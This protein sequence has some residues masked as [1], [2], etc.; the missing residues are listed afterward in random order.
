MA[1]SRPRQ[2]RGAGLQRRGRLPLCPSKNAPLYE[3]KGVR[4]DGPATAARYWGLSRPI[5]TSAPMSGRWRPG[6]I[7]GGLMIES[8][9]AI[10][11]LDDMLANV[12]GIGFCLIGEGDLSQELG[13]AAPV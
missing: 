10:E 6:R 3:P 13:Y 2:N 4:G 1:S 11:N 9:E 5:I 12:P 7:A 8:I